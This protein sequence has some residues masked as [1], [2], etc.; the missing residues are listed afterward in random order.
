MRMKLERTRAYKM[1]AP[2]I[3]VC[4][5]RLI[6]GRFQISPKHM[7]RRTTA[8]TYM[9]KVAC[10]DDAGKK[11]FRSTSGKGL[12]ERYALASGYAEYME[13]LENG[14][15]FDYRLPSLA[16]AKD[17]D[18]ALAA[19]LNANG[20]SFP[21]RFFPDEGTVDGQLVV[22]FYSV[23]DDDIVQVPFHRLR[24]QC[25]S[26][27]MC[28]G[29]DPLEAV[30]QGMSEVFERYAL[31]TIYRDSPPLPEIPL[32]WFE[33]TE[34]LGLLNRIAAEE[35]VELSVR[36]CSLGMGLPVLGLLIRR[37]DGRCAFHLGAD[38]SPITALERCLSEMYQS[39]TVGGEEAGYFRPHGDGADSFD[40]KAQFEQSLE[41]GS[42]TWAEGIFA[43]K[44]GPFKGFEHPVSK[45]A[46]DDY[47]YML[48]IL[49]RNGRALYVRD[50]SYMGF[51]AFQVYVPG[52][53]E[54]QYVDDPAQIAERLRFEDCYPHLMHIPGLDRRGMK[55]MSDAFSNAAFAVG[56]DDVFPI[57]PGAVAD[58][59]E[60][61]FAIHM[62]AGERARA[63]TF[64]R[65]LLE[66]ERGMEV[67]RL[68]F[69]GL[70][71]D[72]ENGA[73][74][75]HAAILSGENLI[76]C[77]HCE[78]CKNRQRC[79]FLS[80]LRALRPLY[81]A[82]AADFPDQLGLRRWLR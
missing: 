51:P 78:S 34:I 50:V 28:A 29:N 10:V 23:F 45:S 61:M 35:K 21:H 27:G 82:Q 26:N 8:G 72:A 42:G 46:E 65:A 25:G 67:P 24:A 32:E 43:R 58:R 69:Q 6:L 11:T 17:D 52:M 81:D 19:L 30:L 33:G 41:D 3:T 76:H 47:R 66:S 54:M 9:S 53:T 59:D 5:I 71:H 57:L 74:Y 44:A 63:I 56:H 49:R 64:L 48:D 39:M 62:A 2:E 15:L 1:K 70:L 75:D 79:A 13:R 14:L 40:W 38:P 37:H 80:S 77:Y 68:K 20:L 18:P 36:D 60:V 12:T 73:D 22:P 55:Q 7:T 16:A 31:R 4:E